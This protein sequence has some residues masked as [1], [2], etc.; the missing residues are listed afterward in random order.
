MRDFRITFQRQNRTQ[1]DEAKSRTSFG[2]GFPIRAFGNDKT[3]H[4]GMTC[5]TH[6]GMTGQGR[7][8][9]LTAETQRRRVKKGTLLYFEAP[10]SRASTALA[11]HFQASLMKK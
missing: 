9:T 5:G 8:K 4:L 3:G 1:P 6:L 11:K 7:E 10:R 2:S